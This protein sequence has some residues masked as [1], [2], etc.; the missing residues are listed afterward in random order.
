[1]MKSNVLK[2]DLCCF[3]KDGLFL[4]YAIANKIILIESV[5]FHLSR[6]YVNSY[7]VDSIEF[8]EDHIHFLA[9][10]KEQGCVCIYSLYSSN[11]VSIIQD[12]F[13]SYVCSFFLGQGTNIFIQ[14]YERKC[15]SIYDL[16]DTEH[17][18]VTIQ[19]VKSKGKKAYCL[20]EGHDILAC[21]T[22]SN[23]QN[24]IALLCLQ[25][26]KVKN[27]I[28]C[29]NF[30]PSEIFFSPLN[31]VIAYSNK[32]KSVHVYKSS[33]DLLY[34]YNFGANL[35][36]VTV[37]SNNKE[38]N[39]LSLGMEDGVVTILH[40]ENLKEIKKIILSETVIMNE[41]MKIYKENTSTRIFLNGVLSPDA[42][43]QKERKANFSFYSNVSEGVKEG[44]YKLLKCEKEK[45]GDSVPKGI[46]D[47]FAP[48]G[49]TFL[50]FSLCGTFMS[51][52]SENHNNVVRIYTTKNYTCVAILQQKK[53]ITYLRWD[54]VLYKARLLICTNSPHLFVWL[55]NEC[56]ILEMPCGF[57]CK[58][59]EWNCHG[60]AL[61]AKSEK[62]LVVFHAKQIAHSR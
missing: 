59:A 27:E 62:G 60:T 8:S 15:I 38:R 52:I 44:E 41:Q 11:L 45:G 46:T 42:T 22:E 19:H 36:C 48:V 28:I 58:E 12:A 57:M 7:K 53:K 2:C 23:K 1:M 25:S 14:K 40:L 35:A 49:I 54:H 29:T 55:P 32:Y 16:N 18:L 50:S 9:L 20:S 61:L 56:S 26:Y 47:V 51:V 21:L 4:L 31:D 13:Q 43:P 30:T 33:G 6:V 24:R 10:A 39:V 34:V 37:A 3:S 17:C 5:S